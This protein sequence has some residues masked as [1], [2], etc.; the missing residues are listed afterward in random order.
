MMGRDD[1]ELVLRSG[2]SAELLA[3]LAATNLDIVIT[4][5]APPA[6]ALSRLTARRI[7][8]E[9]VALIGPPEDAGRPLAELLA[10]RPVVL[11]TPEAV[12]R[13][14]FDA[15]CDRL[16]LRPAI[17]AEVDDMA[18]MRLLAREGLGLAVMPPIVVAD[19]IASGALAQLDPLSGLAESYYAVTAE[20]R[21][22]N[23]LVAELLDAE[24]P[25]P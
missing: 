13:A 20:R 18:M 16:G 22:P 1:L 14:G 2:T 25:A 8:E 3:G 24:R 10:A 12:V 23:P 19:E 15:F 17:A 4:N 7:S 5:R 6:D 21:F 9:N 11:P